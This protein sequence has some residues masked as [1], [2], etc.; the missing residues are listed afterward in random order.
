MRKMA[1]LLLALCAALLLVLLIA[2]IAS[3]KE[4]VPSV[5]AMTQEEIAETVNES[6]QLI[7]DGRYEAARDM[8]LEAMDTG[9][10]NEL[11][12]YT[13]G[14][15]YMKEERCDIAISYFSRS[16]EIRPTIGALINRAHCYRMQ[17]RLNSAIDDYG[18]VIG[19]NPDYAHA[20]YQRGLLYL[21]KDMNGRALADFLQAKDLGHPAAEKMLNRMQD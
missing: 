9:N 18:A 20:Y 19:M 13:I 7:R 11:V 21:Q 3:R 1:F 5:T 12:S 10:D 6:S 14:I 15:T 8:L 4:P 2:A 16:I 17:D